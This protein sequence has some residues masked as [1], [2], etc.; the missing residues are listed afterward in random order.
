MV[1]SLTNKPP[2]VFAEPFNS[3]ILSPNWIVVES[4]VV[5]V[6]LTTKFPKIVID[7]PVNSIAVFN[8]DEYK[9]NCVIDVSTLSDLL[10]K[11]VNLVLVDAVNAFVPEIDAVNVSK[12]FNLPSL[13]SIYPLT[14]YCVGTVSSPN[15][16]CALTNVVLL[17]TSC[18]TTPTAA[19][20]LLK[21]PIALRPERLNEFALIVTSPVNWLTAKYSPIFKLPILST[22]E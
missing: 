12:L 11:F 19:P 18:N 20:F 22:V 2:F 3:I 16:P 4:I 8:E 5:C 13:M 10:S 21:G 15:K 9:F 1:G 7:D 14:A 6:P 17:L